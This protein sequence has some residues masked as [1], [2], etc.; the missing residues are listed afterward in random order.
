MVIVMNGNILEKCENVDCNNDL[1]RPFI[2]E[3]GKVICNDCADDNDVGFC[4][5]IGEVDGELKLLNRW[6][7]HDIVLHVDDYGDDF[8]YCIWV[9]NGGTIWRMGEE[10]DRKIRNGDI[11]EMFDEIY[12]KRSNGIEKCS[13]CCDEFDKDDIVGRKFASIFCEDCWEKFKKN[14][15]STCSKCGKKMYNCHC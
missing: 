13:V 15:S 11:E 3:T 9:D 6:R 10:G 12:E 14:N 7:K 1:W 4:R 8:D 5:G 2:L